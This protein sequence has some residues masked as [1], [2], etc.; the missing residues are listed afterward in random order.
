MEGSERKQAHRNL[1]ANTVQESAYVSLTREKDIVH[2]M[3]PPDQND[4]IML[5]KKVI[6]P[7]KLIIPKI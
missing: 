1:S 7:N 5:Q 3:N 2:Y 6:R 4:Y